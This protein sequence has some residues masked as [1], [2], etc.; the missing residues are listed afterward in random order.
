SSSPPASTVA[1]AAA[2]GHPSQLAISNGVLLAAVIFLFMV[3]VFV[4]L[5]YL[6]AKRFLGANP[7]LN[8]AGATSSRFIFVGDSPFPRRGLPASV[9]RTLP[10]AVYGGGARVRGVPLGG[11][12]RREGADAAQ[13]RPPL[14]RRLHRH[15]V[16][17]PRHLPALPRPRRRRRGRARRRG[18]PPRAARGP[19]H[20]GVPHVPHQRPLLGHPRRRHQRRPRRDAAGAGPGTSDRR[21]LHQLLGLRAQEGEP[22]DRHPHPGDGGGRGVDIP[23]HAAAGERP[24]VPDVRPAPVAAPAPEQGQAGRGGRVIIPQPARRRRHRAGPR[25]APAEDA[26]DASGG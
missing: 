20:A 23:R 15:V 24:A 17:L 9:L 26:K 22:G 1:D 3:V 21:R 5:L 2:V 8:G 25:R 7:M 6:Y 4:F 14:P 13:V 11:G 16:P 18:A 12:R 10:V 19:R